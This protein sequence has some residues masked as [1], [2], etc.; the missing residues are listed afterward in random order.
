MRNDEQFGTR[1][2]N[3]PEIS[4]DMIVKGKRCQISRDMIVKGTRRQKFA[5]PRHTALTVI[6]AGAPDSLTA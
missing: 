5:L 3:D 1:G 4:R 2:G 6:E